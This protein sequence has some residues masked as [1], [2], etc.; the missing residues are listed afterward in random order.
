VIL[1]YLIYSAG[2][3]IAAASGFAML[4]PVFPLYLI[5]GSILFAFL[6]G[7]ASGIMPSIKASK[8]NPVDALRYE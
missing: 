8:L 3:Q 6:V 4:Q 2:G 7:A 5:I 1:G